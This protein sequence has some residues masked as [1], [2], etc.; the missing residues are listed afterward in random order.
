M[1]ADNSPGEIVLPDGSQ[2]TTPKS[3][4][5]IIEGNSRGVEVID[6]QKMRKP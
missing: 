6:L 4:D 3:F 5:L 2:I 1:M